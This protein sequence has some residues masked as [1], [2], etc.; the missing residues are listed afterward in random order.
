MAVAPSETELTGDRRSAVID[1]LYRMAD[2]AL[3]IGHRESEWTGLG[4]ILEEDIAFSSMAQDKMGHALALYTLLHEL[5]EPDPNQLAFM[6]P[7]PE[8]RCCAFVVLE[9]FEIGQSTAAESLCNN[10]VRDR[11]VSQGDWALS[12]TRQFLFS[13]ADAARMADLEDSSYEPL[14]HLARKFR[15]EIKYHTMHGRMSIDR[16]GDA[17]EESRRRMSAAIERLFPYALGMFET[18]KWDGFLKAGHFASA[19]ST[20]C[21]RWLEE[22]RPRLRA[23]GLEIPENAEPVNGGRIG[24]HPPEMARLVDDLQKVRR[25]DPAASW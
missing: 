11:L 20:L 19:E 9:S 7:A 1:L 21:E 15:G 13:E 22:V 8:F 18:T 25:L 5:G 3:I 23:A 24:R 16:L 6:R 12:C 17:T 10:P 2:D 4:P 14:A